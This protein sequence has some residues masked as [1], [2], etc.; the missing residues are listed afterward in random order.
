MIQVRKAEGEARPADATDISVL[1]GP[2]LRIQNSQFLRYLLS[3]KWGSYRKST[4][5]PP[6]APALAAV[7]NLVSRVRRMVLICLR[8]FKQKNPI[9]FLNFKSDFFGMVGMN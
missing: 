9:T 2:A 3:P 7:Q 5:L 6:A 1:S 8:T 4:S